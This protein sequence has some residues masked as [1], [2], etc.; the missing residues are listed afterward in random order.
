MKNNRLSSVFIVI[1]AIVLLVIFWVLNHDNSFRWNEMYRYQDKQPYDLQLVHDHLR[2]EVGKDNFNVLTKSLIKENLPSHGAYVFIG[3]QAFYEEAETQV[4]LDWAAEGNTVFFAVKSF[5]TFITKTFFDTLTCPPI[6]QGNTAYLY[7]TSLQVSLLHPK[8][9][10]IQAEFQFMGNGG[11]ER[12]DFGCFDGRM[13]CE[14]SPYQP[15][16]LGNNQYVNYIRI[17]QGKGQILVHCSPIMFTN[18]Y[19]TSKPEA[20]YIQGVLSHINS[21]EILWD[22]FHRYPHQDDNY[23]GGQQ[24]STP[25]EFVLENRSLRWAFYLILSLALIYLITATHRQ[26]RIVKLIEPLRNSTLEFVQA[27]GRLYFLQRNHPKLIQ[28][29][30]RYFLH[31][32][33][34]RYRVKARTPDLIQLDILSQRSAVSKEHIQAIINEYE[35]LKSYVE[36]KDADAI[37]FHKLLNQ[38]YK[39]CH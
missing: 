15:L 34:E 3:V 6:L 27:V 26:Q 38:F 22:E 31:F 25:L 21:T 29:Q 20:A 2:S 5:D 10:H 17:P 28:I 35:R 36:L 32:I 4:L 37:H 33:R 11:P 19:M 14:N 13:F 8:L 7:D 16:G 1:F 23:S 18:Y 12:Y 39:T 24:G 30:M 9:S